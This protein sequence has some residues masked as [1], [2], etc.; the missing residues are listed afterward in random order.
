[1]G[2][3]GRLRAFVRI[4]IFRIGWTYRISLSPACAFRA[5]RNPAKPNPAK[6]L[7]GEDALGRVDTRNL[8]Q[9]RKDSII[10]LL[11]PIFTPSF[12]RKRESRGLGDGICPPQISDVHSLKRAMSTRARRILKIL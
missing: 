5:I 6:R 2:R 1:M 4:R 8:T 3:G 11:F 10:A 9:R 12:P 7:T